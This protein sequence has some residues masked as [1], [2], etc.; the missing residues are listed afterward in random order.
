ME[1]IQM[2]QS[3][4]LIQRRVQP[5]LARLSKDNVILFGLLAF[6]SVVMTLFILMPLWAMLKKAFRMQTENL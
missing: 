3:K 6:L 5:F 2:M 4:L 1:S